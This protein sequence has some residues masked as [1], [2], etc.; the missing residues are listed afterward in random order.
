MGQH[1]DT[2]PQIN[3]L[4]IK[5]DM[6]EYRKHELICEDN[7][8]IMGLHTYTPHIANG[9]CRYCHGHPFISD[10]ELFLFFINKCKK[11]ISNQTTNTE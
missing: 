10:K 6:D 5:Y 8:N 9:E 3:L 7:D 11:D 4:K 2:S 1:I